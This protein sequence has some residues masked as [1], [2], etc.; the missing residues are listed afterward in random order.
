MSRSKGHR[1]RSY[2]T[3]TSLD[4]PLKDE[5]LA[6]TAEK[7]LSPTAST[8]SKDINSV[9]YGRVS[10]NTDTDIK[11]LARGTFSIA[12]RNG[13]DRDLLI[14]RSS[15]GRKLIVEREEFRARMTKLEEKISGIGEDTHDIRAQVYEIGRTCQ[16]YLC[17]RQRFLDTFRRDIPKDSNVRRPPISERNTAA[18]HGNAVVDAG[19]FENGARLGIWLDCPRDS[20][21][22]YL[23]AHTRYTGRA[24]DYQSITVLN[25]RTT[26]KANKDTRIHQD[27]E[28]AWNP[29]RVRAGITLGTITG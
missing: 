22:N 25:A 12:S 6:P 4:P 26:L 27:V 15:L 14:C 8:K 7:S 29:F 10:V 23:R 18:H 2:R 19:L 3:A 1:R 11:V 20:L 16:E 21:V 9:S 17:I 24:K 28:D 5:R 13:T